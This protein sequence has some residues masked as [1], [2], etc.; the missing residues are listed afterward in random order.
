MQKGLGIFFVLT[1]LVFSI[2]IAKAQEFGGNPSYIKWKQINTDTA[3]VIFPAG[4]ESAGERVATIIHD[5]QKNHTSTIG[6]RLRKINIVL[7]NQTTISNAYV[8]LGPYRS[9]FYLFAPQNSF[10]LGALNWT[11]NLAVH[12]FRHVQQYNNFN[13]GLSKAAG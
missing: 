2:I 1:V 10:S 7:Q 6:S 12:E 8:G 5:L 13:V 11:D 9:E 3:R 4:L